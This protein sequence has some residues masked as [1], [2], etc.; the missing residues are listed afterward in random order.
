MRDLI[1]LQCD[2]CK[3]RNYTTTKNKKSKPTSL[4]L[5]SFALVA[6]VIRITKKARSEAADPIGE[7]PSIDGALADSA[8][9]FNLAIFDLGRVSSSNWQS[10]GLQIRG[11]QV[12]ILPDP[13]NDTSLV[14]AYKMDKLK[15]YLDQ[16]ISFVQESWVELPRFTF[17]RRSETTQAT[18]VVV[19]LALLWRY[20][21]D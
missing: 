15:S 20:G 13:P 21:W 10:I 2:G 8:G 9:N 12:R 7:I 1:G 6:G 14:K 3:R 18:V 17:S 11:L 5:K 4:R 16:G 19:V